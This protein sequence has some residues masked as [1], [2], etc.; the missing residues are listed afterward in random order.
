PSAVV[1]HDKRLTNDGKWQP[2]TSEQYYSAEAALILAHKWSR[3]DVVEKVLADFELS[4]NEFHKKAAREFT[5]RREKKTLA[6]PIDNHNKIGQF[7]ND[8]NYAKHRYS[9]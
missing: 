6:V 2:T 9:L 3:P 8:G 5:D 7:E 1:F 4:G